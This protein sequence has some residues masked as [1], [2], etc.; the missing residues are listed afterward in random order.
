MGRSQERPF[1][2]LIAFTT[3]EKMLDLSL[4]TDK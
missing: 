1:D 3:L 2:L 4:L